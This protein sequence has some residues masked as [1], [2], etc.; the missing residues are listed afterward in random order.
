MQKISKLQFVNS[1]HPRKNGVNVKAELKKI[2]KKLQVQHPE[3]YRFTEM[4]AQYLKDGLVVL[5]PMPNTVSVCER[6][7]GLSGVVKTCKRV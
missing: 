1:Y 4:D 2:D 6:K 5:V 7:I 3:R